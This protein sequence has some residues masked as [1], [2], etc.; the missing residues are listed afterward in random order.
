MQ[1]SFLVLLVVNNIL[2]SW[3][4]KDVLGPHDSLVLDISSVYFQ[5]QVPRGAVTPL[6]DEQHD[7]L[8]SRVSDAEIFARHRHFE[9][10]VSRKM[11]SLCNPKN[12]Y[13]PSVSLYHDLPVCLNINH[14]H[15]TPAPPLSLTALP[16][17]LSPLFVPVHVMCMGR[18]T[19][20]PNHYTYIS[21][22]QPWLTQ[23]RLEI[24]DCSVSMWNIKFKLFQIWHK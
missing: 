10:L 4:N 7:V 23:T 5:L 11:Q 6:Y 15:T 9:N 16:A 22:R 24:I 2:I 18:Y 19:S 14:Y 3:V 17:F 12:C 13:C 8:D 20:Q 1:F 21:I